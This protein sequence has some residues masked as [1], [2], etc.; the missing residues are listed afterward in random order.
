MLRLRER[1]CEVFSNSLKEMELMVKFDPV[2][3]Q[4]VSFVE[5]RAGSHFHYLVKN[6]QNELTAS[7]SS[8]ILEAIVKETKTS[9]YVSIVL[10]CTPDLSHKEQLCH[11]QD[12]D[13]RRHTSSYI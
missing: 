10:D 9:K 5:R 13:A 12:R 2:M 7:I 1:W 11:S 4:H 6:I 3:E 8:K